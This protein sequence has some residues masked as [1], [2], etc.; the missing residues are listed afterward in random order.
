MVH[1]DEK[2]H[3]F[4]DSHMFLVADTRL[5]TLPCTSVLWYVGTLQ[6]FLN[7]QQ[8]LHYSPC[9]TVRDCVVMYLANI[10]NRNFHCTWLQHYQLF[11]KDIGE[12]RHN[13][14]GKVRLLG[15][16][17]TRERD[18]SRTSEREISKNPLSYSVE[19]TFWFAPPVPGYWSYRRK[20]Q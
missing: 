2:K 18:Q 3:C 8:F 9:P 12:K 6:L 5:Y 13:S 20:T 10:K 11:K 4:C 14:Q 15:I 7:I 16:G 17:E 19:G 1:S